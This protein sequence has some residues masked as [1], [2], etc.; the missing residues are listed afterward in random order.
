MKKSSTLKLDLDRLRN[1][2]QESTAAIRGG[3]GD[4]GSCPEG[5]SER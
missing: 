1:L 2:N 5:A 4:A 3:V